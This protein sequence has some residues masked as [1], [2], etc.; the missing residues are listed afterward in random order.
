MSRLYLSNPCAFFLH[1]RTRRCGRSRCPA[2]PAPSLLE[3]DTEFAKLGR[4]YA[5]GIRPYIFSDRLNGDRNLLRRNAL[6]DL[7]GLDR[8]ELEF[9]DLAE[10]IERGIGQQRQLRVSLILGMQTG[11]LLAQE[12]IGLRC[13]SDPAGG[14]HHDCHTD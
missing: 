4:N 7:L 1:S 6:L 2:F 12:G 10:R 3:R 5:A 14:E 9:W 8:A 13:V 11:T